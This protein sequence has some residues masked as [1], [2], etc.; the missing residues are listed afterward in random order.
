MWKRFPQEHFLYDRIL[1]RPS[2]LVLVQRQKDA[3]MVPNP[4]ENS[5]GGRV[6]RESSG[7]RADVE[8]NS[9]IIAYVRPNTGSSLVQRQEDALMVPNPREKSRGGRASKESPGRLADVEK[10][11][12]RISSV[13]SNTGETSGRRPLQRQKDTLMVP[14][15]RENSRGGR[16][17]RES[18]GRLANMENI[19]PGTVSVRSNTGETPGSRPLQRQE[20]ALMVPNPRENSRGGT[21]F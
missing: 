10:K 20:D 16:A 2:V 18:S 21:R 6:S 11:S 8:N 9:S 14:N 7:R 12:P 15:P 17:S 5:R 4:R 1:E 3:L 13:R 19:S